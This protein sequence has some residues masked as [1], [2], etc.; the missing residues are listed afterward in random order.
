M[1][2]KYQI[3]PERH[4]FV[5]LVNGQHSHSDYA[6]VDWV[7]A[8]NQT[9][10][11]PDPNS[12]LANGSWQMDLP[13]GILKNSPTGLANHNDNSPRNTGSTPTEI[14]N[15]SD[16]GSDN[17]TSVSAT[18]VGSRTSLV[19]KKVVH[20]LPQNNTVLRYDPSTELT[21]ALIIG[22]EEGKGGHISHNGDAVG[23]GHECEDDSTRHLAK[24]DSE[25]SSP[26]FRRRSS[27]PPP[28][29]R[30]L[31]FDSIMANLSGIYGM[32][33]TVMGAVIPISE[34]FSKPHPFLFEGFY[35]YLFGMSIMFLLYAY[36]YILHTRTLGGMTKFRKSEDNLHYRMRYK[37]ITDTGS[38][39]LRL[40]AVGFGIG[41]M[42]KSGLQFGEFFELDL[43]SPCINVLQRLLPIVHLT[44]TFA[45]L[46][47]VFLN[48]KMCIQSYKA[49]A[50]FGLMH[51]VGTNLSVWTRDLVKETIREIHEHTSIKENKVHAAPEAE[52]L[53]Y[54]GSGNGSEYSFNQDNGDLS[55]IISSTGGINTSFNAGVDSGSGKCI[56]TSLM[57]KVVE[58]AAPYLYPCSI[59]YSLIC[60]GI[61]YVM[62]SNIGKQLLYQSSDEE[63]QREAKVRS[64][65]LSVDCS[66]SSRGLFMGI[67]I[68]VSA[69]ISMIVFFM[70]INNPSYTD[71][72]IQLEH[73]S[74]VVLNVIASIALILA[75]VRMKDL[76]F[77]LKSELSL[78]EMLLIVSLPG[79]YIFGFLSI[80]AIGVEGIDRSG[81]IILLSSILAIFESS[82]QTMFI[83]NGIRRTAHTPQLQRQKTGREFI[84]FLM[85]CNIAMWGIYTFEI[86][87]SEFNPAQM[88]FYGVMAWNIF[89]HISIPL[90]IFF[91]F[92]S[93]VCLSNIWKHAWKRKSNS[94]ESLT[95]LNQ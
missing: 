75:F 80:I 74:Q 23:I 82:L 18:G 26:S 46:Y 65:K 93:T 62:W 20:S 11:Q 73:L 64:Q 45:Q 58:D 76:R 53:T 16:V 94:Q 32:F 27:R 50:R 49:I 15:G 40:G 17:M 67:F 25:P 95:N 79:E 54:T 51:M 30:E 84:T 29:A 92:H 48:S 6:L 28:T 34:V 59:Q 89:T 83:L 61:L 4:F 55:I 66:S 2:D 9:E 5:Q 39:Y 87:R 78:E 22:P 70:L 7:P 13:H 44:F 56:E 81:L 33:L 77:S 12:N 37:T 85:V 90:I 69:V 1:K 41:S 14:G 57:S 52:P 88:R 36:V 91:R 31:L 24:F 42:I 35:F 86:H 68:L 8:A 38:F 71:A 43:R 72:A 21:E 3:D 60:A 10:E 19:K 47:F 63:S